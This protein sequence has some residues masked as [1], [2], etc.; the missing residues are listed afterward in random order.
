MKFLVDACLSPRVTAGLADHGHDAVHVSDYG[1]G[2]AKD[3]VVM[4]KADAEGRVL[5]SADSD[6]G[7]LLART[8]AKAP[9][10]V[11]IRRGQ[12]RR[13]DELVGLLIA[14]LAT[15]ESATRQGSVIVLAE[16]TIR[17]RRLPIL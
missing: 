1:L 8:G 3:E 9:S 14:N 16:Q 10:V 12:N 15:I 4:A 6:F 7:M 13:V 5:V 11:L 2:T 17:I